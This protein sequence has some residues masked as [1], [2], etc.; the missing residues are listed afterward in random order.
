MM[1]IYKNLLP[2]LGGYLTLSGTIDFSKV[3]LIM[4]DIGKIEEEFFRVKK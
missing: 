3:D 1:V 2:T 4:N